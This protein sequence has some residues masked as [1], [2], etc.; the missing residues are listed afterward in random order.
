MQ[1]QE[2]SRQVKRDAIKKQWIE[3]HRHNR[4]ED[5]LI[6]RDDDDLYTSVPQATLASQKQDQARGMKKGQGA[7]P[8]RKENMTLQDWDHKFEEL[9]AKDLIDMPEDFYNEELKFQ[10]PN[11][12]KDIFTL[13]E[14]K[15]LYFIHMSQELEQ[16]IESQK[17]LFESLQNKLGKERDL[18]MQN[19]KNLVE[20]ITDADKNLADLK[21]KS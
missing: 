7:Q 10:D 1:E 20:Q 11:E 5:Y 6:F 16:A 17:Q 9:I 2:E 21:K 19:K 14:E 15:N 8:L 3:Y 18:H 4:D 13:L 12:L